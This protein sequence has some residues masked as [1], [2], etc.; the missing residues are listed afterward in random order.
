MIAGDLL[1]SGLSVCFLLEPVLCCWRMVLGE[2]QGA[3]KQV[4][5]KSLNS[6]PQV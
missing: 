5:S 1:S 4:L 6:V 2:G 3:E